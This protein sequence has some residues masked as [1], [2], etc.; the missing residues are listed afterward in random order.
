MKLLILA[1]SFTTIIIFFAG[2]F[3]FYPMRTFLYIPG[4][5]YTLTFGKPYDP[6]HQVTTTI[7]EISTK[8]G[9]TRIKTKSKIN[10]SYEVLLDNNTAINIVNKDHIAKGSIKDL[11][12]NAEI[13]LIW[14]SLDKFIIAKKI[15][16][17][18]DL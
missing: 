10:N 8:E 15:Y 12:V 14:D 9:T 18:N 4:F 5:E 16:I 13:S 1:G 3:F 11:H 2:L 7:M 6:S 17:Y